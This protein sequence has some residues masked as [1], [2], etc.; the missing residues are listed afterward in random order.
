MTFNA[1]MQSAEVKVY[2]HAVNEYIRRL[3]TCK[4]ESL[5]LNSLWDINQNKHK[6][7]VKADDE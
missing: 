4:L 6:E 3:L 5:C 1:W 2:L 7:A